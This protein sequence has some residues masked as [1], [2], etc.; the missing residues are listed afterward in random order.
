MNLRP[1]LVVP[2]LA[3]AA[4]IFVWMNKQDTT[5]TPPREEPKLAVRVMT[6]EPAPIKAKAT[7]YG[8]AV[9]VHSWASVSEVQGRIISMADGLAEGAIVKAGDV[10]IEIDRTDYE[11]ALEKA[12]ANIASVNAQLSELDRQEENTLRTLKLEERILSVAQAEFDRVASLVERG[13]ATAAALDSAQKALLAQTSSVTNLNNTM[14]LYPA[15]RQSLQATLSVRQAELAEAERAISK[16]VIVAPFRGRVSQQ[17]TEIGQFVRSGET[18]LTLDDIS[19][20]E[21]TAE[22]QPSTFAP[23]MGVALNHIS[24][25]GTVIDT[26]QAVEIMQDIGISANVTMPAFGSQAKWPA[27]IM[28]LRGTMNSDTGSLGLVV[29]VDDPLVS[30]RPI[31]RPPLN[32]GSFV[33]VTLSTLPIDGLITIPRDT[34]HYGSEG[35]PYVYLAGAEQRLTRQAIKIG[36]VIGKDLLI[37][38]GLG[39]GEA[40]ILSDPTPP[41]LGMLLDPVQISKEP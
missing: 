6:V 3:L 13:T 14:A 11:L 20:V 23:M 9:A 25:T 27:D 10:L 40:L 1:F 12:M 16:V 38:E 2:P 30:L 5:E 36:P 18:L 8:R 41:V 15:K 21:I 39:G 4:V 31:G 34:V 35:Q 37:L 22:F 28:R 7:G 32:V 17:N 19:A 29:R 26:S 24:G 33:E